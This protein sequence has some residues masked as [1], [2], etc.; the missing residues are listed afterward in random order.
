MKR[1]V[2]AA[3][4]GTLVS[5]VLLSA[6]LLFADQRALDIV[7]ALHGVTNA[8]ET[9][10]FVLAFLLV[11]GALPA[12][13]IGVVLKLFRRAS[14]GTMVLTPAILFAMILIEIARE[15]DDAMLVAE[16]LPAMAAGGAMMFWVLVS[17]KIPQPV[18]AVFE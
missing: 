2:S 1:L 14:P 18:E 16:C 17:W 12:V 3:L 7:Q 8:V 5:A 10:G 11:F 9:F 13:V 4:C 6:S 15:M